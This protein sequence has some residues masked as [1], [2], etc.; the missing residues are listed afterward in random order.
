[1]I[2]SRLRGGDF[3]RH[4]V[5]PAGPGGSALRRIGGA[6]AAGQAAGTNPGT[7]PAGLP[8]CP[9]N[10][11][12]GA[13]L[14]ARKELQALHQEILDDTPALPAAMR[15][16]APAGRWEMP[17]PRQLTAAAASLALPCLA[18]RSIA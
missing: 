15:E 4:G 13:G 3:D 9:Q 6:D 12:R 16:T 11:C 18:G 10:A 1:V 2:V 17:A 14:R 7:G 8:G 5:L